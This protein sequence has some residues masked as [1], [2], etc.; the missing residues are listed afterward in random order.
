[1]PER[2]LKVAGLFAGIGGFELGFGRAGHHTSLLVDNSDAAQAVLG[3]HFPDAAIATDVR[4]VDRL[5]AG[6][7][8]VCAGFP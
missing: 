5:P 3:T 6:I 1:M 7:D 4:D 2:R 8:V